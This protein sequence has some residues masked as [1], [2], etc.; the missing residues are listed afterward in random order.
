MHEFGLC[1]NLM[2]AVERRAAGRRV[3]GVRVRI[4]AQHRVVKPAFDQA[5]SMVTTGSVADGAVVDWVVIPARISCR[6]CGYAAESEDILALCSRCGGADLDVA[7]GDELTLESIRL[8]A[9]S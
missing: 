7:G 4:G 1:F 2:R 5:F 9:A 3:E 8:T 6:D